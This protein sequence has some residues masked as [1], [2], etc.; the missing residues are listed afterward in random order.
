MKKLLYI[1]LILMFGSCGPNEI[2]EEGPNREEIKEEE[3]IRMEVKEELEEEKRIEER[4]SIKIGDLKVMTDDL[5]EM[6]WEEAVKACKNLGYGW[7]LPT[8]EE[9]NILYENKDKIGGFASSNY[10]SSTEYGSYTAWGQGFDIG[11]QTNFSK[12]SPYY[13]RA[14]R[15][16]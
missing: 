10:W 6:N 7:R 15:A 16:F 12:S 2:T 8:K 1:G 5:G 4:S 14:V 13:V 3:R 9:L 11:D